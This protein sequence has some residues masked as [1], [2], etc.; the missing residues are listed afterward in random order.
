MIKRVLLVLTVFCLCFTLNAF[1]L[2]AE[3]YVSGTYQP[4]H[5][6]TEPRPQK[7]KFLKTYTAGFAVSEQGARYALLIDAFTKR[8][9]DY[10]I[11]AEYEDPHHK[12]PIIQEGKLPHKDKSISLG[13]DF[14]KGL[15]IKKDYVVKVYLIDIDTH[16]VVDT[17]T[18]KVR[19]YVD[20]TGDKVIIIRGLEN[21]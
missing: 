13:T 9:K 18:Q 10:L 19:S 15:E 4:G 5:N 2:E 21:K 1:Y 6:I 16:E 8:K 14:I 17:L 7:S 20:T 12:N 11:K 3:T